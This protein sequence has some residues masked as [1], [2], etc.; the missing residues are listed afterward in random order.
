MFQYPMVG[1]EHL[2]SFKKIEWAVIKAALDLGILHISTVVQFAWH[3]L[4]QGGNEDQCTLEL[5][6]ASKES[7][8][9][10]RDLVETLSMCNPC[11]S[12][13]GLPARLVLA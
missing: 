3:L 9:E 2:I 1:V 4:D 13:C 6:A 10:A 5:A 8:G 7:W 12:C 11:I